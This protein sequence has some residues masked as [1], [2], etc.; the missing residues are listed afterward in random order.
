MKKISTIVY[1]VVMVFLLYAIAYLYCWGRP[2]C[3]TNDYEQLSW[4]FS[5]GHADSALRDGRPDMSIEM[6]VLAPGNAHAKTAYT[7]ASLLIE[8]RRPLEDASRISYVEMRSAQLSAAIE[9]W[10]AGRNDVTGFGR[11]T[12]KTGKTVLDPGPS[13]LA[14]PGWHHAYSAKHAP[15]WYPTNR[16]TEQ[17]FVAFWG[18][19]YLFRGEGKDEYYWVGFDR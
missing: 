9:A 5:A 7:R 6:S 13:W 14:K 11:G 18:N 16:M 15:D 3:L 12:L 2:A 19:G 4:T 10:L 1:V 17:H 8:C